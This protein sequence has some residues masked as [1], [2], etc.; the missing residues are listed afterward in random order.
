MQRA[1]LSAED[2]APGKML[3]CLCLSETAATR[4][5]NRAEWVEVADAASSSGK[6]DQRPEPEGQQA[7]RP[8][9][10]PAIRA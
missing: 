3:S 2:V 10:R 4:T 7:S 9:D 1:G 5:S 8:D 6:G